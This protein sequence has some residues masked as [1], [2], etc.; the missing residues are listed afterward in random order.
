MSYGEMDKRH[1]RK[2]SKDHGRCRRGRRAFVA[3]DVPIM[4]AEIEADVPLD[5]CLGE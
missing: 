1:W 3:G 4:I 2:E 5:D